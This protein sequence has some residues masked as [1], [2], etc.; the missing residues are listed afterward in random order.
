MAATT[1]AEIMDPD[2]PTVLA[3]TGVEDVVRLFKEQEIG[4]LPVLNEARRCVGIVTEDDLVIADETGDLHLPHYFELFGGIVYLPGETHRFEERLKKAAAVQV[5]DLMTHDP[6][7]VSPETTAEQAA[8][9][10][11]ERGYSRLP[12]VEHGVYRGL[13][14]RADILAALRPED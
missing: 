11:V 12:V 4:A 7:T 6:V 10:I 3:D 8:H 1:V 2:A 5:K 14:T 9:V 13:V